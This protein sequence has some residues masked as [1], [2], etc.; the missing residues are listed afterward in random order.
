MAEKKSFSLYKSWY[1]MVKAMTDDNR[2][3][4]FGAIYDYQVNGTEPDAESNIYPIFCLMKSK[5]DEDNIKYEE[6]CKRNAENGAKGGRPK[7]QNNPVGFTKTH[8]N[9]QKA[10]TDT[11]TDTDTHTDTDTD[12]YN[13]KSKRAPR[14]RYGEYKNV[15]LSDNDL[16]VLNSEYGEEETQKAIKRLDEYIETS[17][18]KYKNHRLVMKNWVFRAVKEDKS[19]KDETDDYLL[20]VIRGEA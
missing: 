9:P 1:P 3:K 15:L 13:K 17:G 2:G 7:T 12:I 6:A 19:R 16:E 8:S 14:H 4:L 5:F 11:E 10:D 18:K 20:K